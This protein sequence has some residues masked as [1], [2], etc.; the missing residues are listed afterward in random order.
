MLHDRIIVIDR[1]E[2]WVLTQSLK[3]IANRSPASIV[4]FDDPKIKINA[5]NKI[6]DSEGVEYFENIMT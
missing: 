1:S 6:W 5:Y 2:V 3:D 4:R